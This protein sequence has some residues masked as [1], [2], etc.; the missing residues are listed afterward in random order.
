MGLL[1]GIKTASG[2]ANSNYLK[3]GRTVG[4][5]MRVS[6][7]P[8]DHEAGPGF[9]VDLEVLKSDSPE[10]RPG[11]VVTATV[12]F[13]YK[14]DALANVRRILAACASAAQIGK[15][16]DGICT[17]AEAADRAEE[18][19]GA[20]QPLADAIVTMIGFEK[21]NQKTGNPYTLYEALVPNDQDLDSLTA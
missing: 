12:G 1:D 15:G 2:N 9:R 11:D 21:K 17:E 7:R 16:K 14:Q 20:E 3:G 18:L 19:V 4:R 10:H 6:A 5:I 8:F 13:K